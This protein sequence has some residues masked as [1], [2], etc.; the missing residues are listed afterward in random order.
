M[1]RK[2]STLPIYPE[3]HSIP[4]LNLKLDIFAENFLAHLGTF[5]Q[6]TL[7]NTPFQLRGSPPSPSP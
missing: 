7:M 4:H 2:I 5:L 6:T 3:F 1:E